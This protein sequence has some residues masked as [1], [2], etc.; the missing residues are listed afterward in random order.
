MAMHKFTEAILARRPIQV[1]NHG[2][3]RRDFTYIDDV[4][5][6]VVRVLDRPAKANPDWQ[7]ASPD[8][9]SSNS[10]YRLYNIGNNNS[11][12]LDYFIRLLEEQLQ[13]KAEIELLPLQS[14]DMPVTYADVDDFQRDF[15]FKPATP[16]ETGIDRFVRWYRSYYQA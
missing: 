7:G 3:L 12:E 2:K 4:V 10:P 1:F 11:V 8:P 15:G 13:I 14:G 6:G 16:I 9:S 5:E